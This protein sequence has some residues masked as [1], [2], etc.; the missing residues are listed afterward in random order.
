MPPHLLQA[1]PLLQAINYI[2]P[3][4]ADGNIND[5]AAAADGNGGREEFHNAG[6]TTNEGVQRTRFAETTAFPLVLGLCA[7]F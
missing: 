7:A 5:D 2:P 6:I 4:A 1:R 3:P